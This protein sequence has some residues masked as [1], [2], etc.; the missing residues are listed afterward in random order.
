M[1]VDPDMAIGEEVHNSS[2]YEILK[3]S[4]KNV[5]ILEYVYLCNRKNLVITDGLAR[6]GK[7]E[8]W[9][10]EGDYELDI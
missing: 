4:A 9:S 7:E 5:P 2:N 8:I 3:K 1:Y 10:N 6:Y